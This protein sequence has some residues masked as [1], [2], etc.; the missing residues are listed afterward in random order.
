[1]IR[2][3]FYGFTNAHPVKGTSDSDINCLSLPKALDNSANEGCAGAVFSTTGNPSKKYCDGDGHTGSG[4]KKTDV[5]GKYPWF[6]KCCKWNNNI[7][8]VNEE[9][10]Q[11]AAAA[12]AAAAAGAAAGEDGVTSAAVTGAGAAAAEEPDVETLATLKSVYDTMTDENIRLYRHLN[13]IRVTKQQN[14]EQLSKNSN[15]INENTD[16]GETNKRLVEIKLNKDK[17]T[18]YIL[19]VLKICIIIIG[20]LIVIPI[21]VKLKIV[22]KKIGLIIF[23]VSILII[24]CVIL[25]F[26]YIKNYNRDVNNF[27]KFNFKNPDST[28]IA[29]SKINV[30]LS[31][32]D[33]ARCQAFSEIQANFDPDTIQLNMID[34]I[35]KQDTEPESK[36]CP[37][38]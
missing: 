19:N 21:L 9:A 37:S 20:C 30:E 18:Y 22:S 27:S 12:A 25:Y 14:K 3:N 17:K 4:D 34:Y 28:E 24:V 5:L 35:T 33:Q 32:S 10:A 13:S 1:M 23:G 11:A 2:E 29:K 38:S 26:A 15:N 31:E 36:T 16:I 6:K 7:C 8:E